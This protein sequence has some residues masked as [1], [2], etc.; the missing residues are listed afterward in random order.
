MKTDLR[1]RLKGSSDFALISL[2]LVLWIAKTQSPIRRE[3]IKDDDISL[4]SAR[5]ALLP[6]R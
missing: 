2:L 4:G 3:T 6:W 1:L 5:L